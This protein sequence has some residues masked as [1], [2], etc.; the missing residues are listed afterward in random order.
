M[1]S[2]R[3]FRQIGKSTDAI[4]FTISADKKTTDLEKAL[5]RLLFACVSK[6]RFTKTKD[7]ELC[8]IARIER[9]IDLTEKDLIFA[10]SLQ[11][12][13][14]FAWK[15]LVVEDRYFVKRPEKLEKKRY[16]EKETKSIVQSRIG[17]AMN[18]LL[19]LNALRVIATAATSTDVDRPL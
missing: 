2:G 6:N 10:Q 9:C 19:Y 17:R 4:Y 14:L 12:K 1:T 11:D 15:K 13:P 5:T 16:S 3:A 7:L 18:D 8:P